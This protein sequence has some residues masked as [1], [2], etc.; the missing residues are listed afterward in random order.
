MRMSEDKVRTQILVLVQGL[1]GV[2][3]REPSALSRNQASTS[4]Q[5]VQDHTSSHTIYRVR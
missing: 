1:D 4:Q 2:L 5:Q 3:Q